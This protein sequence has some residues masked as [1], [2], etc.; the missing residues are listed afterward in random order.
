MEFVETFYKKKEKIIKHKSINKTL[1]FEL[2]NYYSMLYFN[3]KQI[4]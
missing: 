2:N 3:K 4:C 1:L